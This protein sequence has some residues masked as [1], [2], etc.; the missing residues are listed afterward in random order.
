M[1][2]NL[3]TADLLQWLDNGVLFSSKPEELLI[4]WGNVSSHSSPIDSQSIWYY[5]PDFFLKT[6]DPWLCYE[7]GVSITPSELAFL[8]EKLPLEA[9]DTLKWLPPSKEIFNQ[10]FHELQHLFRTGSMK[11]GVPYVFSKSPSRL[12]LAHRKQ[13][14]LSIMHYIQKARVFAYGF[15]EDSQGILGATPELLFDVGSKRAHRL[16][17]MALAGTAKSNQASDKMLNDKKLL[18]EH[19]VV[20]DDIIARL[21]SFGQL[22]IGELQ[23][24]PLPHLTHL[25]TPISV[26][27]TRE[28]HFPDFVKALHPTPALGGFPRDPSAKW[29]TEYDRLLQRGR[30]GAP[31]GFWDKSTDR[32]LCYVAIRNIMWD[33]KELS[34]GAGCGVVTESTLEDEWEEILLKT[35]AITKGLSLA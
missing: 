14:L 30:F 20:V 3:S 35:E 32:Q 2:S 11:K 4:G 22:T 23:L 21:A 12:T 8:L 33:A 13:I 6:K 16:D 28:A 15:W 27:L 19:Q 5:F 10:G 34:I 7:K 31:A 18:H 9:A 26:E 29:L 25:Y 17:T 1:S 24:L